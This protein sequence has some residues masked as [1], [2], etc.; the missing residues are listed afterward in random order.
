VEVFSVTKFGKFFKKTF[1]RTETIGCGSFSK[2]FSGC[3]IELKIF[4]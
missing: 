3:S 2:G 1:A 4:G